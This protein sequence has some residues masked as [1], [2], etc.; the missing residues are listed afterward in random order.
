MQ[1]SAGTQLIQTAFVV[2]NLAAAMA[3]YVEAMRVGPWFVWE[4]FTPAE[5][6]YRGRES[7]VVM[8][9]AFAWRDELMLEL[10]E[11]HDDSPSIFKDVVEKRG[12]GLHHLG[13]A[14]IGYDAALSEKR[15]QGWEVA[16]SASTSGRL[17]M[18]EHGDFPY[19][20]ELLEME[21]KRVELFSAIRAAAR[22]WNGADPVRRM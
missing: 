7:T 12:Y 6:R 9:V 4:R 13:M 20:L 1:L 18:L 22:S 11:Q 5:A 14:A 21:P 3:R 19:L 16:F 10:I 8:S 2:E 17:S 15:A